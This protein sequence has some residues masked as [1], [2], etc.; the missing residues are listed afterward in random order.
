VRLNREIRADRVRL[1][2][3]DGTQVGVVPF[4]EALRRAE[5]AGLDLVE[6]APNAVPPVCKIISYGK[7]Q[8]QITKREKESRKGQHQVKVKELKFKPNIDDHDF[9]T[10]ARHAR[11]FLLRGDKVRLTCIFRGREMLHIMR[12]EEI[13]NKMCKLLEDISVVE[14]PIKSMGKMITVVIAPQHFKKTIKEKKSEKD[15]DVQGA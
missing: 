9:E 1:I 13:V 7:L 4:L 2:S 10:K 11:E 15:E 3:E 8:Y 14:T 12:G 5:E 6:I